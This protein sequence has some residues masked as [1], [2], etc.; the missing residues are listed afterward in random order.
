MLWVEQC[1]LN[2]K[3]KNIKI[4]EATQ[5]SALSIIHFKSGMKYMKVDSLPFEQ[6]FVN[7]MQDFTCKYSV[8]N[9]WF[10]L[11][12]AKGKDHCTGWYFSVLT[13]LLSNNKLI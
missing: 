11:L 5:T 8:G 9:K 2:H 12:C 10:S 6:A 1:L 4:L 7:I 3:G 13:G